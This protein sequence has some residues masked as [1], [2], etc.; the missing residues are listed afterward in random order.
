MM[1]DTYCVIL[2]VPR[3]VDQQSPYVLEGSAFE[4]WQRIDGT[5]TQAQLRDELVSAFDL[6]A[7]AA[8][9]DVDAFVT[10]LADLGLVV[11]GE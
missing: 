11:R 3:I 7:A 6:D 10:S 1:H 4:I 5:R 9:R 2:N 8:A